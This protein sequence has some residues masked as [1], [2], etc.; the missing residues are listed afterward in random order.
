MI[1][2]SSKEIVYREAEAAG[3][4]VLKTSTV[5]SIL[6]KEI[7]KGDV[8]EVAKVSAIIGVKNTSTLIP[9]THPIPIEKVDVKFTVMGNRIKVNCTVGAHYKTGVEMEALAGVTSALLTIWDM[10]KYLEKD[11][12]GQY[13]FTSIKN[14]EVIKKEKI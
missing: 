6:K 12:N 10:V 14:I 8:F 9:Y 11:E 3:E 4:I 13:P 1:D 7:T 5:E 2:I